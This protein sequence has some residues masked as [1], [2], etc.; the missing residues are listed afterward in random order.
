VLEQRALALGYRDARRCEIGYLRI[1]R[2]HELA[3]RLEP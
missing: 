2:E 3:G 1:R